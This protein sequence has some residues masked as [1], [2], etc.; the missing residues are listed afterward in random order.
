MN[1]IFNYE[2]FLISINIRH[3]AWAGLKRRIF[4]VRATI[5]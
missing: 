3:L 5:I 4:D 1:Y 2:S